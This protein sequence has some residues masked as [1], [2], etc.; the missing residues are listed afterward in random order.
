[1]ASPT[2]YS[3]AWRSQSRFI[4][5]ALAPN[6]GV[7]PSHSRRDIPD[8]GQI[9][10]GNPRA[11]QPP[12]FLTEG[13]DDSY[14]YEIDTPGLNLDI[15]PY[16]HD[17]GD[18]EPFHPTGQVGQVATAGYRVMAEP[19]QD[20]SL[21]PHNVDRGGVTA[22]N[23]INVDLRDS[24]ENWQ[25]TRFENQPTTGDLTVAALRGTNSLPE[26]NPD[27]YRNGWVI[28]RRMN[29]QMFRDERTHTE[30]PYRPITAARSVQSPDMTAANSNRYTSPFS[31]QAAAYKL[32]EQ[33]PMLRRTPPAWDQSNIS[34]GSE[35]TAE[36]LSTWT[37]D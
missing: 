26:N 35:G 27:G 21:G 22:H 30:R 33:F 12:L 11:D 36:D 16:T 23:Y 29:R 3:G 37:V 17:A 28:W 34:D 5:R 4:D 2:V 20:A 8:P 32:T 15:E 24:T 1:M 14:A 31:W 25:T 9:S 19:Y 13:P 6:P 10:L 7:D 18:E